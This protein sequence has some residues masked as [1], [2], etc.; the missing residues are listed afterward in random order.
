VIKKYMIM[1]SAVCAY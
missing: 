1:A